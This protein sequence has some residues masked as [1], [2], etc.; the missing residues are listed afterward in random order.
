MNAQDEWRWAGVVAA[1][2]IGGWI[3]AQFSGGI[4]D[5]LGRRAFLIYDS[6][7]FVC[8]GGMFLAAGLVRGR[9][10]PLAYG[11]LVTGRIIV[12]VGSGAA[13]VAV[14]LYLN[15]IATPQQR[16]TLGTLNQFLIT[17]GILVAQ[18]CDAAGC[19]APSQR[20]RHHPAAAAATRWV[21]P[22][23]SL[24]LLQ[25][26]SIAMNTSALWG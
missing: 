6:L 9:N 23:H 11:L 13:T 21:S 19:H 4:V 14:P 20:A 12:G 26:V 15:E 5:A 18:V 17:I 8:G 10:P 16:G 2:T 7:I 24:S 3:G 25:G 1:F 22:S